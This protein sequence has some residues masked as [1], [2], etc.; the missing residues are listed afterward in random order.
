MIKSRSFITFLF[1][2]LSYVVVAEEFEVVSFKRDMGSLIAIR[3]PRKD[4]NGRDC[5]V[6][7][8]ITDIKNLSF[9]SNQGIEGN[10][11]YNQGEYWVYVQPGEKQ[12]IVKHAD[13]KPLYF[14]I[15]VGIESG[16]DYVMEL[17]KKI[18]PLLDLTAMDKDLVKITF[19]LSEENVF[20]SRGTGAPIKVNGKVTEY[21]LPKGDYNF[22]F[23]KEGFETRTETVKVENER[24]VDINLV[25][26][27]NS[28]RVRLP[29]IFLLNSE[30]SGA[31]VFL[32]GQKAGATPINGQNIIAGE[33]QLMVQKDFYYNYTG[34]F[35]INEGETKELPI[36]NLKPRFGYYQVN[37]TP[38]AAT[39]YLD[40][41]LIGVS[42]VTRR[43]IESGN[44]T[45]RVETNLYHKDEQQFLISNGDDKVFDIKLNPAFGTL[46]INS[47]PEGASLFI[48]GEEKGTTPYKNEN[49]PSGTY[50][51]TLKSD[52]YL[53]ETRSV[54][55]EDGKPAE[56]LLVLSR[57]FGKI[58]I[59][60]PDSK[61]FQNGAFMATGSYTANLAPGKYVFTANRDKHH[62]AKKE[63]FVTVGSNEEF[64]LKPEP[65]MGSVSV[66]TEPAETKGAEIFVN[67]EKQQFVTPAVVPLLIGEYKI[68][69]KKP[70]F[71]D[72]ERNV[73]LREYD[74]QQL[75]ITMQTFKG[76]LQQDLKRHRTQKLAWLG[77]SLACAGAGTYFMLSAKQK[78]EEYKTAG[79]NAS[80][81]RKQIETYDI[82]TPVFFGASAVCL[83]PCI[84][85]AVRQ[86]NVKK[87]MNVAVLPWNE[88]M[89]LS[90][91]YSF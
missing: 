70:G 88:G 74:S 38:S 34:T 77:G 57:N 19:R 32:N 75:P 36:I 50:Q 87:K 40:D 21:Q 76:S 52:L 64:T 83:V 9:N 2:F 49:W 91:T 59:T 80:D 1:F 42:P 24:I 15:E 55:V 44:H 16:G 27:T 7:K 20:I 22:T 8:V 12:L 14:A 63:V 86:K 56:Q 23:S 33:Y 85:H 58:T 89:I 47:E 25:A 81:L 29:G 39:V 90:M 69:V 6:I 71:L 43:Q 31:V 45:L 41:K 37:T 82:L 13:Y 65:M 46:I 54:I 78:Y 4:I 68:T 62:E 53:D 3:Y 17:R 35:T 61:I 79:E 51:I 30:P 73:T 48:D 18:N 26:G 67:G 66:F 60:A 5:A 72:A 28:T 10:V 11:A 84:I